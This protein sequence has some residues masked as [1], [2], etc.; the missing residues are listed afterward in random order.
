MG[1]SIF[2]GERGVMM[3]A[4]WI[5]PAMFFLPL[6]V[7]AVAVYVRSLVE[8]YGWGGGGSGEP[9]AGAREDEGVVAGS[10]EAEVFALARGRGGRLRASEVVIELGVGVKE[11]RNLLE[12]LS[13]NELVRMELEEGGGVVFEFPELRRAIEESGGERKKLSEGGEA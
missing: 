8:K 9:E 13:D 2:Y 6:C 7:A 1:R 3:D 12:S 11:A 4:I 5:I 10:R